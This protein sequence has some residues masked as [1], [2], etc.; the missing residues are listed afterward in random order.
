M[1]FAHVES[2]PLVRSSYHAKRQV[3]GRSPA[4][5]SDVEY[6]P[7]LWSSRC[8]PPLV[9]GALLGI[10]LLIAPRRYS[11]VK[12]EPFECGKDP[13][14]LPEG[15]FAI[16]FST[17]AIFFI[18]FDIELLFVWPWAT[19]F[20]SLGWFGFSSHA[21]LPGHPH[22]RLS[23]HLEEAGARMGVG[24]FF[25]S[26]LDEAIGWARKFSIFQY[27]FVTACCGMEYMA[28][29]C[30][31]YDV[32]RFGAGL[33]RF[34][35]RQADVLFVVGTISHKMAPV[36]KRI[37]DQMCE[38]KW[39]V[40]FGV[41]TCTGGFYDNYATVQGIDTIIPVDVYIPGC[42]PRPESVIDGLM[43]LQDKIAGGRRS[44]DRVAG[45]PTM[46][47][48]GA[49]SRGCASA[50]ARAVLDTHELPRRPHGGGA[51]RGHRRG[52]RLLPGRRPTLAL[53]HARWT[54]PRWTT[55]SSRPRGRAALR[56]RLSPLLRA[57][58]PSGA[59][60]GAASSRTRP[61]SRPLPP[62]WPIANWLEREVWDMFG[63]RFDGHPT[64]AGCCCT[65]SSS[66]IRCAR[67]TRSSAA[68]R[69]SGRSVLSEAWPTQPHDSMTS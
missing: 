31:H 17:I 51:P 26:K 7:I 49:F 52:A 55:S 57:A 44:A 59:P 33:P 37:Y 18:I 34:S 9:A 27:P 16:K 10:P 5:R 20:A 65:R 15:R 35:P 68:S 12:M 43:K 4:E 1:G 3:D 25:T 62:L 63:I 40:A 21:G 54:S 28:T 67:T 30:S 22:A 32:D 69:S 19:V 56:R 8:S 13:I 45:D 48:I 39:V 42:P 23:L 36:L 6:V 29:A 58:Q 46:D 64:C 53:R 11:A 50:S 41:C 24:T 66:A 38:P 47:G 60:Q 2:G 14:A 61:W